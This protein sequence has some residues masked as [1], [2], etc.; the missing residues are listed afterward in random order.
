MYHMISSR[1]LIFR[2]FVLDRIMIIIWT[3]HTYTRIVSLGEE[4]SVSM[5]TNV[6]RAEIDTGVARTD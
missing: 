3:M 1:R 4:I 5:N 6:F 2:F